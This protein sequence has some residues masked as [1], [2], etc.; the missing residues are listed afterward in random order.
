M[1]KEKIKSL[2]QS[3]GVGI[4]DTVRLKDSGSVGIVCAILDYGTHIAFFLDIGTWIKFPAKREWI[5]LLQ[6]AEQK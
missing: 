6:S 3:D 1:K 4:G 5:E 2:Q